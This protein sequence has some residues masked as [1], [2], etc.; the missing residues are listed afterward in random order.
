MTTP[1][2]SNLYA[3]VQNNN[4]IVWKNI[5]I[6]DTDGAGARFA[7]VVIGNFDRGRERLRLRFDVPRRRGRKGGVST[8]SN[9]AMCWSIC[10]ETRSKAGLKKSCTATVSTNCR[11]G[12]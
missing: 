1:E 9:G 10:A 5:S 6:V 4:N 8:S 2:T 11:T 3:N 7:D 12:A